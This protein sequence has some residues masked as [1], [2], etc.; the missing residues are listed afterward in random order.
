MVST[1]TQVPT[2]SAVSGT[3]LGAATTKQTQASQLQPPYFTPAVTTP[4]IDPTGLITTNLIIAEVK[5]IIEP[6]EREIKNIKS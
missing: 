4:M 1:T 6:L 2:V 3:P 5:Q